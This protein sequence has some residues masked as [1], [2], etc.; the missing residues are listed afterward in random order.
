M[1][2]RGRRS[3][4]NFSVVQPTTTSPRPRLTA[5]SMLSNGQRT[6]FADLAAANPHLTI[7]D[8]PMLAAYCQAISKTL[9]LGRG[10]DIA[11]WEKVTRVAMALGRSLRLT[12]SSATHPDTLSRA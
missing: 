3:A 11:A 4:A 5:P 6:L 12:A 8:V 7:T 2:Q 9:K 1:Q 10:K